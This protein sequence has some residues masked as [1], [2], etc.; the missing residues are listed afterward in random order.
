MAGTFPIGLRTAILGFDDE[1]GKKER[2]NRS[3]GRLVW[4]EISSDGE[5][6]RWEDSISYGFTPV[7]MRVYTAY[8]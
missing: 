7:P 5:V 3:K 6:M 8:H 2:K 4:C 1:S